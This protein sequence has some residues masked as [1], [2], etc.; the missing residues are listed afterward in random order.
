MSPTELTEGCMC[1]IQAGGF[2][3]VGGAEPVEDLQEKN[4]LVKFAFQKANSI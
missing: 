3:P 2:R 4:T 1:H